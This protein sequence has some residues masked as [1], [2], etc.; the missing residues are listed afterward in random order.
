MAKPCSLIPRNT[1]SS[2]IFLSRSRRKVLCLSL[3]PCLPAEAPILELPQIFCFS[4]LSQ[5]ET[6]T[7]KFYP[8]GE[9]IPTI[10]ALPAMT[11]HLNVSLLA[12]ISSVKHSPLFGCPMRCNSL[13]RNV[14]GLASSSRSPP[15]LLPPF[16][17]NRFSRLICFEAQQSCGTVFLVVS[18]RW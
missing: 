12:L 17:F 15:L 3:A 14:G 10:P 11:S 5:P 1:S 9:G 4:P 8:F 18:H 16:L 7:H 2:S 13:T 6:G